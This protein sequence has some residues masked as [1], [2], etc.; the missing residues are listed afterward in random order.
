M[1]C[2]AAKVA[3]IGGIWL[4]LKGRLII[5]RIFKADQLKRLLAQ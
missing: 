2:G 5:S 3:V 1:P 4:P